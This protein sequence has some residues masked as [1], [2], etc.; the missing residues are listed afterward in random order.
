MNASEK[1][2]TKCRETKSL[3]AFCHSKTG[4]L[5]VSSRCR[6]CSAALNRAYRDAHQD[7][8]REKDREQRRRDPERAIWQDMIRRCAAPGRDDFKHYGG[9][10]IVVAAEWLGDEGFARF[11]AHVG[12][13]PSPRH[14]IDR[15]ENDR[16]YEPGNVRWA[17]QSEQMRNCSRSRRIT[18]DGRTQNLVAWAEERGVSSR[19]IVQRIDMLGWSDRDAVMVPPGGRREAA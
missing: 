18:V 17:T 10:G 16:N 12:P 7:E 11:F 19:L 8:L 9:R 3:D 4:R 5:G 15:I 2:C 6:G 1:T 13:R 14:S